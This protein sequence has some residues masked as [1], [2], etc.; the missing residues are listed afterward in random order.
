MAPQVTYLGH[1]VDHSG[2]VPLPAKVDGIAAVPRPTSKVELQR[3]LG[4]VNF[5]H[6]FL[7]GEASILVPL[8]TLTSSVSSPK[9][10]L[11]WTKAQDSAVAVAK[12]A[13]CNATTLAH[14]I[15]T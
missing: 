11:L 2:I 13:L 9:S 5:F 10:L 3:F 8:H 1:V 12:L 6:R 14:R 7:P 4:C 15:K